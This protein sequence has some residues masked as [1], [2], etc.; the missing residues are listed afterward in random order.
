MKM[1]TEVELSPHVITYWKSKGY[2]IHG[3]VAIFRSTLFIDHVAHK[4]PCSNP[5]H[6]IGIEMKKGAGQSLRNQLT[7]LDKKHVVQDLYGMVFTQ[8]S[9]AS[10]DRWESCGSWNQPGLLYF[11]GEVWEDCF[12]ASEK[13]VYK[14]GIKPKRLLLVDS[15]KDSLAGYPSGVADNIYQTHWKKVR[16]A[17]YNYV[18]SSQG[19][20]KVE[21]LLTCTPELS[22]YKNP[23]ATLTKALREL[24]EVERVVRQ[25]GKEG[26]QPVFE[27]LSE[28]K[29]E[30]LDSRF[31]GWFEDL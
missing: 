12:G 3:E 29:D 31:T 4:G 10:R 20:F 19:S 5:T 23:E 13:R 7:K 24:E 17:T 1:K 8:P 27:K 16:Q 14:K 15:N 21:D 28:D 11:D 9:K 2:C 6:V 26:K 25:V 18:V 30:L 22:L